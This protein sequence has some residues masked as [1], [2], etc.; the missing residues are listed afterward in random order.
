MAGISH[1]SGAIPR[2]GFAAAGLRVHRYGSAPGVRTYLCVAMVSD[3]GG[4][5]VALAVPHGAGALALVPDRGPS[6]GSG[7]LVVCPQHPRSLVHTGWPRGCVLFHPEDHRA[8][9]SQLLPIAHRLLV[10]GVFLCL[11]WNASFDRGAI[12]RVA[13]GHERGGQRNDAVA[14]DH[15]GMESSFDI[16]LLFLALATQSAP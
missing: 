14:G 8:A 11:E 9:D 1:R 15:R 6:D 16:V 2:G 3:G 10:V 13:G 12:S 5:L 4:V 7:K